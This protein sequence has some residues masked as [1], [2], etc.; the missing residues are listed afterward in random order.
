MRASSFITSKYLSAADFPDSK[1]IILTINKVMTAVLG[2]RQEQAEK[3]A[4]QLR[5]DDG[6]IVRKLLVLNVGNT[7]RLAHALGDDMDDWADAQVK[8]WT[9]WTEFQ[10]ERVK[11]IRVATAARAVDEGNPRGGRG[12]QGGAPLRRRVPK[13]DLDDDIPF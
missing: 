10:G 12:D 7:K 11:G 1:P 8:V 3:P 2:G 5:G 9:E 4:L 13:D 6:R